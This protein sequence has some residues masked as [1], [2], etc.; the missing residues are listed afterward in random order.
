M[1][2]WV[3]AS[4]YDGEL[5]TQ[6]HLTRKGAYIAAVEAL[7]DFLGLDASLDINDFWHNVIGLDPKCDEIP[8]WEIDSDVLRTLSADE[9]SNQYIEMS[10]LYWD[11]TSY[12]RVDLEV[13]QTT[14]KA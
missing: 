3:V 4:C 13:R 7:W 14:L 6:T 2:I 8:P 1:N 12:D 9:V 5:A 10:E 11:I